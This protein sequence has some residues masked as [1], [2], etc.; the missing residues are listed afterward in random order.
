MAAQRKINNMSL[1]HRGSDSRDASPNPRSIDE[2]D[3][4]DLP[5]VSFSELS[6][7]DQGKSCP[8]PHLTFNVFLFNYPSRDILKTPLIFRHICNSFYS[9]ANRSLTVGNV[10]LLCV[11]YFMQGVGSP[12]P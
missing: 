10:L 8:G 12:S 3:H 2:K 4:K 1:S 5:A 7:K 6:S 9:Y 11:L